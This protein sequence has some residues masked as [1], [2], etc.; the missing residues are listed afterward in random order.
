MKSVVDSDLTPG[1]LIDSIHMFMKLISVTITITIIV[2]NEQQSVD[3]LVE[4]GVDKIT[5]RS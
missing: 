5:A 1:L 4:K 2:S 3:H